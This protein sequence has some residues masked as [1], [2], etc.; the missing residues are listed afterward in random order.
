MRY[1]LRSRLLNREAAASQALGCEALAVFNGAAIGGVAACSSEK[2]LQLLSC[3]RIIQGCKGA[4]RRARI[5]T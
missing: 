4:M 5:C 1:A 2:G 3:G